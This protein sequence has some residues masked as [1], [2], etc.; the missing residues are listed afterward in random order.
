MKDCNIILIHQGQLLTTVRYNP[1]QPPPKEL[2]SNFLKL[3]STLVLVYP[4]G[5][6]A[7]SQMPFHLT[8]L[9]VLERS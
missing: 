8:I 4:L 9:A 3:L 7:V 6:Y 5:F 1:P 2:L